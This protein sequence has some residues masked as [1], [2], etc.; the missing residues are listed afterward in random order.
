[1]D[2]RIRLGARACGPGSGGCSSWRWPCWHRL[3]EEWE[4]QAIW[5]LHSPDG[6][7]WRLYGDRQPEIR[8]PPDDKIKNLS[9][10]YDP[11]ADLIH[12]YIAC[13]T[14]VDDRGRALAYRNYHSTTRPRP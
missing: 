5:R 10:W 9:A 12:G 3:S 7:A 8:R 11:Q 4:P 6:L 2:T 13:W 14:D 1:M